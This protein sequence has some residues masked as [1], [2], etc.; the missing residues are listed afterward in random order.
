M[1]VDFYSKYHQEYHLIS[2]SVKE[3]LVE[4]VFT[5]RLILFKLAKDELRL[6]LET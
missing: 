6:S 1:L 3:M 5:N 4:N 2:Y